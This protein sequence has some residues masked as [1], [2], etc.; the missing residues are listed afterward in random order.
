MW[1]EKEKAVGQGDDRI[2]I[3]LE[4]KESREQQDYNVT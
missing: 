3:C 1:L 4:E 2:I